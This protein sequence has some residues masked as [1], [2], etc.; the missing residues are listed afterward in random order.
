MS[1]RTELKLVIIAA[2]LLLS[3]SCKSA[4][5]E[6]DHASGSSAT[7]PGSTATSG[8]S[9]TKAAEVAARSNPLDGLTKAARAMMETK[10]FRAKM[11]GDYQGKSLV[12]NFEFVGPD[13]YH[14]T[15]GSGAWMKMGGKWAKLPMNLSGQVKSFRDPKFIEELSRDAEVKFIGPDLLDGRP[16][17]V[18]QYTLKNSAGT[19]GTT[20]SKMWVG[21]LDGLPRKSEIEGDVKGGKSR[22][23]ITWYDYNSDISI[24][25]PA[26]AQEMPA[27]PGMAEIQKQLEK[28]MQKQ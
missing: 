12:T 27:I 19:A 13:R 26:G 23:V 5:P 20:T 28:K 21:P 15:I 24:E 8:S 17:L 7:T 2:L 11:E 22:M 4:A 16:M 9:E 3:G 6:A 18:Y 25:P 1:L 10:S 14:I